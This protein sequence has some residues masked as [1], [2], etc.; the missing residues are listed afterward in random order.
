MHLELVTPPSIPLLS[1]AEMKAHLRRDDADDDT[2]IH[3]LGDAA[4]DYLDAENGVTGRALVS[5][6]W[7]QSSRRLEPETRLHLAPVASITS[8]SYLDEGVLTAIDPSDY[9]LANGALYFTGNIPGAADVENAYQIVFVAGYGAPSDVPVVFR[10]AALLLVATWYEVRES[11]SGGVSQAVV[12]HA[13][14]M[15]LASIR[16]ER[17]LF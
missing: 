7:R 1:L 12:P 15:L 8:V 10:H 11:V 14:D 16:T 13:F 9:Y 17:G 5:Q 2:Y 6:T 4:T 3:A